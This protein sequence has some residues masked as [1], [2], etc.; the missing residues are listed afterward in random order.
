MKSSL[1]QS[2]TTRQGSNSET[3]ETKFQRTSSN[4]EVS[5]CGAQEDRPNECKRPDIGDPLSQ[6]CSCASAWDSASKL[7]K[8]EPWQ[9]FRAKI[10]AQQHVCQSWKDAANCDAYRSA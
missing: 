10:C 9:C 1:I 8:A 2:N 4:I 7:C 5:G 3:K 6:C